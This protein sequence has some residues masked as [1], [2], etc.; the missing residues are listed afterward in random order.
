MIFTFVKQI[1]ARSGRVVIMNRGTFKFLEDILRDYPTVQ[2]YIEKR[3]AQLKYTAKFCHEDC[4]AY[5]TEQSQ[6]L[7][8]LSIKIDKQMVQLFIN[9]ECIAACL[10]EADDLTVQI[11]EELYFKHRAQMNLERLAQ[12]LNVSVSGVSMRRKQFMESLAEK[13]GLEDQIY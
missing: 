3:Q 8:A 7:M 9:E 12:L 10:A 5:N 4:A 6:D 11:I 13:L 2:D 1:Q